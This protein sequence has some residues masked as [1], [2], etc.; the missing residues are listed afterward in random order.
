MEA[1]QYPALNVNGIKSGWVGDQARTIIPPCAAASID[2]RMVKGN[3]PEDMRQKIIDHIKE[4]GY[5]VVSEAPDE[6]IRMKYIKMARVIESEQGYMAYKT[7]MDSKNLSG[8][9]FL[10]DKKIGPNVRFLIK[11]Q[12]D[13][14]STTDRLDTNFIVACAGIR[15]RASGKYNVFTI[16]RPSWKIA[17]GTSWNGI[18]K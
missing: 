3:Q 18:F 1:I 4:Q 15:P 11:G 7:P 17:V 10:R 6:K 13:C 16:I 12:A 9:P 2:I 14:F 8:L 5:E